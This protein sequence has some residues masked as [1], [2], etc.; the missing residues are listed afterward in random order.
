MGRTI[1]LKLA[2]KSTSAFISLLSKTNISREL[3]KPVRSGQISSVAGASGLENFNLCFP[4]GSFGSLSV[5]TL[6]EINDFFR[7]NYNMF[8]CVK[9]SLGRSNIELHI[10]RV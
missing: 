9:L 1:E 8:F 7:V 2:N 4:E 6:S 3:L 5:F 10:I